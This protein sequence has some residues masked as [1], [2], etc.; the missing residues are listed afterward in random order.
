MQSWSLE[1]Y[2]TEKGVNAAVT[3]W[4]VSRQAVEKAILNER[5][6]RITYIDGVYEVHE[7]KLLNRA[8]AK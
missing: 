8:R 1:K 2:V 7:S 6:I 5:D 3:I 4:G